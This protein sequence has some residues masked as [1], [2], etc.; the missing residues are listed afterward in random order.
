[1]SKMTPLLLLASA[2][3]LSG[4]AMQPEIQSG[5]DAET[6]FDG[7]VR[8]DRSNFAAAW[9]NVDIDF[10]G[11]SQM[12][13]DD[14]VFE[15]RAARSNDERARTAEIT[16]P[17]AERTSLMEA[18]HETFV[19]ELAQSRHFSL[20][21]EPSLDTIIV[22]IRLLDV[23]ARVPRESGDEPGGTPWASSAG[24]GTLVIEV[25]DSLSGE[26]LYRAVERRVARVTVGGAWGSANSSWAE[27]KPS[28]RS[29]GRVIREQLDRMHDLVI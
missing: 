27:I 20:V 21:T 24:D 19:N 10:S 16:L 17:E 14:P 3:S 28:A 2:L 25:H 18:V 13:V 1:M 4:C 15:F 6:S 5:P 22:Q 11:Y 26:V 29:W 23:V 7:L 9:A 8:V 12:I